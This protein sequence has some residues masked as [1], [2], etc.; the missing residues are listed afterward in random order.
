MSSR[1]E[2]WLA[3]MS[4]PSASTS[5]ARNA[6]ANAR[7]RCISVTAWRP[8]GMVA[9]LVERTRRASS[10]SPSLLGD[11]QALGASL[12]VGRAFEHPRHAGVD[13][14][15]AQRRAAAGGARSP[16]VRQSRNKRVPGAPVHRRHLVLDAARHA[17]RDVLGALRREREVVAAER[18][19]RARRSSASAHATSN[20]ALDDR[21]AP[22]GNVGRDRRATRRRAAGPR[23]AST[24]AT[25][26]TVRPHAGCTRSG[27]SSPVGRRRRRCR[28][29]R[30]SDAAIRA[31]GARCR[32]RRA[33][34]GRSPSRRPSPRGSRPGRRS[35]S[36]GRARGTSASRVAELCGRGLRDTGFDSVPLPSSPDAT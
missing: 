7:T 30:A 13:D 15:H 33:R 25:P 20:A 36:P 2:A 21:P 26:A 11:G 27:S 35:G 24:R 22:I 16:S 6:S 17:G 14:E 1:D 3:S 18:E 8:R 34:R 23:S 5:P 32:G 9:H 4:G 19:A 29:A 10:R 28:R 12:R 31:V